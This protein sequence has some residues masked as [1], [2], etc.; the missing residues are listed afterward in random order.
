MRLFQ[1]VRC[2]KDGDTNILLYG[3]SLKDA[4]LLNSKP[5]LRDR[6]NKLIHFDAIIEETKKG[7]VKICIV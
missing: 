4:L 7:K 5:Y 3:L 6:E 1:I 2:F